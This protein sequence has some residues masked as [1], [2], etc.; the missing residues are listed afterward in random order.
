MMWRS[1]R[2]VAREEALLTALADRL[3]DIA[4]SV[5]PHEEFRSSLRTSLMTEAPTAL[6]P[7]PS[8]PSVRAARIARLGQRRRMVIASAFVGASLGLGSVTSASASA[9]PGEALYPVKRAT[10]QVELA[11]HRRPADRGAFQLELAERRLDEARQLSAGGPGSAELAKQSLSDF[12]E[13][14]AA[15]TATL[16][17]AFRED[18]ERTSMVVLNRFTARTD[19][20]L[21]ALEPELPAEA[22]SAAADARDTV[23]TMASRSEELC[24]TCGGGPEKGPSSSSGS[25]GSIE[26]APE[27]EPE[28]E[29]P[30]AAPPPAK[31]SFS[32]PSSSSS[33]RSD[34]RDE[35]DEADH[36]D[37]ARHKQAK[38]APVRTPA[39][40]P[41][42]TPNPQPKPPPEPET[43]ALLD[44]VP[45]AIESVGAVVGNVLGAP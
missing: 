2:Q 38:P 22:T 37:H 7:T 19:E 12:E 33:V 20:V 40:A 25:S 8:P 14:A 28:P 15:G 4:E 23:Q 42:P 34:N 13:A 45:G 16:M 18:H 30:P 17:A 43:P 26:A 36:K 5:E 29:A 41:K 11:F 31:P 21:K 24:P 3:H 35:N 32:R 27:P 39:P 10:E 44:V 9:L 6:V 1:R